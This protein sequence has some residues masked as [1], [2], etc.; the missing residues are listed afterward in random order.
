MTGSLRGVRPTGLLRWRAPRRTLCALTLAL[1]FTG[2][3]LAQQHRPD[4]TPGSHHK[5]TVEQGRLWC[6]YHARYRHG[7]WVVYG[8][9]FGCFYA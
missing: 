5:V 6:Y 1:V 7:R 4:P 3:A 9:P 2:G 8:K